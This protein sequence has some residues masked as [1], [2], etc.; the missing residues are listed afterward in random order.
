[1]GYEL[2]PQ[3]PDIM[4]KSNS[5]KPD[6]TMAQLARVAEEAKNEYNAAD[7]RLAEAKADL[8][9]ARKA[10]KSAKKAAKRARKA[11]KAAHKAVEHAKP[12]RAKMA[13]KSKGKRAKS[14]RPPSARKP[15]AVKATAAT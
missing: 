13:P 12:G 11:A 6:A 7:Q 10:F 9:L 8:K 14:A 3:T 1:M 5:K 2:T 15:T 4:K